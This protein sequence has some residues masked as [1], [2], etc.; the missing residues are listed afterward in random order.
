MATITLDITIFRSQY[1]A[2]INVI[3]YPDA[4]IQR[5]FDMS[6]IFIKNETNCLLDTKALTTILYLMTAHLLQIETN[7][8]K[9]GN[10][11]NGVITSAAIDKISVTIADPQSKTAWQ[12]FMNQSIYGQELLAL[13]SM[14]SIGGFYF[15]GKPETVPFRKVG[16]FY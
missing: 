8:L 11:S 2:F 15:G 13:F 10:G 5:A 4:T 9:N 14:L 16:G 12:Y 3:K 7:T 1:P 6:E